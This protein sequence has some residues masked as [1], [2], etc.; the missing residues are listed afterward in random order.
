MSNTD[1]TPQLYV[2]VVQYPTDNTF[3]GECLDIP[4]IV[5]GHTIEEVKEKMHVAITGYFE[6]FP[7]EHDNIRK[8]IVYSMPRPV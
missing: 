7:K 3:V 6:A 5:E 4:V 8:R 2:D 1:N